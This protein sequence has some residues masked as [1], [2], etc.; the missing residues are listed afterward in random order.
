[1]GSVKKQ[2]KHNKFFVVF[3]ALVLIAFFS[4]SAVGLYLFYSV[5][6]F[7]NGEI[8]INLDEYKQNQNQTSFIYAYDDNGNVVE[9]ARLHGEED[10]VW[11]DIDDMPQCLLK[12]CVSLEDKRFYSHRGVDWVRV[13]RC[14]TSLNFNQGGSTLTQQLI[15]NLTQNKDVTIVRKYK[16]INQALNLE[17]TYD[18]SVIL[19]AYLNTLYLGNGCY[20]VKTAAEK[21]FGKEV[22]ELNLTECACLLSITN[23]PTAYNPLINPEANWERVMYCLDSMLEQGAINQAEY[24]EA[25]NYKLVFKEGSSSKSKKQEDEVIQSFYVDY[26]IQSVINDLMDEYGLS[27]QQATDKIYYGGLKIYSAIDLKV[28]KVLEDIYVNRIAFPTGTANKDGALTQSAMTVMDYTGR[29]CGII[30][31][32]GPKKGNRCLNRA[33]NSYRQPGST[34]KPL[35]VYAPLIEAN[36]ITFSSKTLDKAIAVNGELWPHNVDGKLGSGSNVTTQ[37]AVEVSLN[38]VPARLLKETPGYGV[39]QSFE[40]LRDKFKITSLDENEDRNLAPLATGALHKGV[41]TV[42]MAAA[43]ATFGNGGVYYKP[44][45]YYKITNAQSTNIILEHDDP[46][47]QII[48][49]ATANVMRSILETVPTSSYG[50]TGSNLSRFPLYCK[51]GTTT[52]D[53]DRWFCAGT[54][55]FVA[56]CWYGYDIP[57]KLHTTINPTGKIILTVL[58]RILAGLDDKEFID[59]GGVVTEKY[60]KV[61]GKLAGSGCYSTAYGVY[62]LDNVPETC[63]YCAGHRASSSSGGDTGDGGDTG[64]NIGIA[65]VIGNLFG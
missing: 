52:D 56:A 7:A 15:K 59:G 53:K 62:K 28:Q 2:K 22:K 45:C 50:V 54:P 39:D 4:V 5:Y 57:E 21:Y 38:T 32:A 20:G 55:Y 9:L 65:D 43:Y 64:G 13:V 41:T 58:N 40:F 3:W 14:I 47:E 31:A 29:V 60:C 49:E 42:E 51:T 30:G 48:S 36:K 23:A 10:R 63:T 12:A 8:A 61:T 34:I 18:K 1:M 25:K 6:S 16:E 19:E 27:K 44:Y 24:E 33:A 37:Y 46:G 17:K 11:L 35:S 26:V